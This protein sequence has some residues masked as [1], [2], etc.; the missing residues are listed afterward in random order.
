M[1]KQHILAYLDSLR[2]P[3]ASDPLHKWI[4]TYNLY[5][6]LI[7]KFFRWLYYPDLEPAKR[8]KPACIQNIS[9]L[10]RKEKSIYKPSD[11]WSQED[12]LLFL[13]FC[14]SKRDRCYHAMSGDT[15][16]RPHE[17]LKLRVKDVVFKMAGDR[18][19]A[20]IL[21]NG[22]TG[23]RH[24][25][26]IDCI[27][28]LKDWLDDHPQRGN[29]NAPLICG[30]AR[31]LGRRIV[32]KSLYKVYFLYKNQFFPRLLD[33]PSVSPEHLP[34]YKFAYL[35]LLFCKVTYKTKEEEE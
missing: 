1:T 35:S 19:Y 34:P 23:N 30:F 24:I 6:V 8:P 7:G 5:A 17:L 2:K 31:S 14:P 13:K 21:V 20:E 28:Y 26:L 3:E 22:K 16:C 18:Q 33:D 10:K 32:T 9:Q 15:S 25:P 27:P 11:L 12:D 4:G 29:P